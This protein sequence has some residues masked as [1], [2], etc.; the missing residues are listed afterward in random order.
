[1]EITNMAG[2]VRVLAWD[3][4]Q[5]QIQGE[6]GRGAERLEVT[7]DRSR[8]VIRV[9]I[10]QNARNVRG[11]DLVVRMPVAKDV[12]IRTTSAD[13]RVDNL[14]G[15]VD[16]Q[17][18]SGDVQVSGSPASVQ[19]RSTSGDVQAIV[20]TTARVRA[21]STSGD[22]TVRGTVRESVNVE[23][24]S[25]DV[26]VSG[27][28][29]EVRAKTVSGDLSLRGV[30]GKVSAS[31]VSGDATVRESRIQFGS[32]ETVSGSVRFDGEL[33]E[34]LG[35]QHSEPQWRRGASSAGE[36]GVRSSMSRPSAAPCRTSS[37]PMPNAPAATRSRARASLHRRAAVEA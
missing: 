33:P 1:V 18:T 17:S 8:T 37:D 6:L 10:P 23:S 24:V 25:G 20:Q 28:T 11:T 13:V 14:T 12:G 4:D 34:G 16:I 15:G 30:T 26:E 7:G 35:V 19:A 31:T 36:C 27:S 5:I 3:R 9:V 22:V 32:F 2:S 21:S 29:P